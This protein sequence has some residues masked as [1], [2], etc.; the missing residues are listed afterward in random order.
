[1]LW[2]NLREEEFEG[3]IERS[4]RLCIIPLGCLE[5]HGQ[6]LPMGTDSYI[7]KTITEKASEQEEVMIFPAGM[8]LGEVSCF[9]SED[10]PKSSRL[11][12]CIGINPTTLL[13]ILE[14]LCDEIA[15]NGFDKILIAN[16]HGGNVAMLKYFVRAQCYKKKD[17]ATMW[18]WA[19]LDEEMTPEAILKLYETRPD[20]YSM[21]TEKDI[22]TLKGY[23]G[24]QYGGG[25]ADMREAA[26]LMSDHPE[27]VAAD[28]FEAESGIS[29][30][31]SDYL[32]K[33]GID[34]GHA[35][36]SNYPNAYSALPPHGCS[37]TIGE[38]MVKIAAE[39]MARIYKLLKNDE[40]C[41]RMAK[42][43]P[44]PIK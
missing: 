11:R 20:D 21:L 19:N 16:S 34:F 7:A 10:D 2:E 35:W 25:H 27:L 22:E 28:K 26:L 8:W 30:H 4:G 24:T 1:M 32:Y 31:R 41:V 13:L 14:E 38:A 39:R 23:C 37:R 43:E 44:L 29:I 42:H 18:T 12:G 36:I 9:H 6:H 17:Y 15:R 3:A 40:D 5:K 33:E